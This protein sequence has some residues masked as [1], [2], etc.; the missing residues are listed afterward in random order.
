MATYR[1]LESTPPILLG[2]LLA[3]CLCPGPLAARA[4]LA[5]ELMQNGGFEDGAAFWSGCGGVNVVERDD[6]GTTATM[7]HSGRG[8]GRI[9]GPADDSCPSL[10]SAQLMIVQSVVIPADAADLTLSFWFSRLGQEIA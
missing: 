7:V 2:L 1:R 10:P 6:P 9:S 5:Q 8:A 4:A 3:S